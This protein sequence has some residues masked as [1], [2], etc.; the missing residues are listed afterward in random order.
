MQASVERGFSINNHFEVENMQKETNVAKRTVQDVI[1]NLGGD[2]KHP[3]Y[4]GNENACF[5]SKSQIYGL[6]RR[7]TK[8]TLKVFQN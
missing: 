1:K 7:P 2:I 3:D 5:C 4:E 6:L 8:T